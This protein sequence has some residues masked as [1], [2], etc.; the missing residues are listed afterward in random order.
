MKAFKQY[1]V[2]NS[3]GS[4]LDTTNLLV[5]PLRA[6]GSV[7]NDTVKTVEQCVGSPSWIRSLNAKDFDKIYGALNY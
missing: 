4:A 1:V 3:I 7:F 5:A 2:L 6:D